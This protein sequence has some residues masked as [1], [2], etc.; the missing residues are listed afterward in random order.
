MANNI[1][2]IKKEQNV[3]TT[4]DILSQIR[5]NNIKTSIKFQNDSIEQVL[6]SHNK[7]I[8]DINSDLNKIKNSK[9]N[10]VSPR[11]H[12]DNVNSISVDISQYKHCKVLFVIVSM[13]LPSLCYLM[14]NNVETPVCNSEEGY[15]VGVMVEVD[16]SFDTHVVTWDLC[17]DVYSYPKYDVFNVDLVGLYFGEHNTING[18]YQVKIIEE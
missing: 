3:I 8:T 17:N 12:F 14:V 11:V 9:D 6:L 15:T 1:Y 13:Q 10:T 2:I 18:Y 7:S 4:E 16:R 5:A